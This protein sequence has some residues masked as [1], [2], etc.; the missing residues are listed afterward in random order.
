M[1]FGWKRDAV[2]K[3]ES[4]LAMTMMQWYLTGIVK[5]NIHEWAFEENNSIFQGIH[6]VE[7]HFT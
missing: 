5:I 2:M 1:V 3:N 6:Y 4:K 7:L